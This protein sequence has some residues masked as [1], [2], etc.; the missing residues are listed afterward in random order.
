MLNWIPT[1]YYAWMAGCSY[2]ISGSAAFI[3]FVQLA[4]FSV[5]FIS[6]GAEHMPLDWWLLSIG[7]IVSIVSYFIGVY[8]GEKATI[9]AYKATLARALL[10]KG[11]RWTRF[12]W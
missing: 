5:L 10:P 1:G 12:F 7:T 4:M 3:V 11:T 9:E 6:G 8:F 2:I